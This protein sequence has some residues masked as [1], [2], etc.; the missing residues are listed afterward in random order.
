MLAE[1]G[2]MA[3][4]AAFVLVN[5]GLLMILF[6]FEE[7]TLAMRETGLLDG[8]DLIAAE[9]AL[10]QTLGEMLW[11]GA[12]TPAAPYAIR[13]MGVVV[14][15]ALVV[16]TLCFLA[17]ILIVF[18]WSLWEGAHAARRLVLDLVDGAIVPLFVLWLSNMLLFVFL[19]KFI[20]DGT[21]VHHRNCFDLWDFVLGMWDLI[22]GPVAGPLRVLVVYL[23]ATVNVLRVDSSLF[24]GKIGWLDP[25]YNTFASTVMLSER[26]NNPVMCAASRLILTAPAD[27]AYGRRV[28]PAHCLAFASPAPC[29][30]FACRLPSE[31]LARILDDVLVGG[32][33]PSSLKRAACANAWRSLHL[34]YVLTLHPSLEPYNVAA[35]R[36]RPISG[37]LWRR[38]YPRVKKRKA[39]DA[40]RRRRQV[41]EAVADHELRGAP[42]RAAFLDGV[43]ELEEVLAAESPRREDVLAAESP[44]RADAEE[45]HQGHVS[46]WRHAAVAALRE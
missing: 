39:R 3:A 23:I 46:T 44:R 43:D 25:G 5:Y 28:R 16:A 42:M 1:A 21:Y 12:I 27:G 40:A 41:L 33:V 30:A 36:A 13:F 45:H 19:N 37:S 11:R 6:R 7:A 22:V 17:A 15:H 38:A 34:I 35:W 20:S 14:A 29:R 2:T 9:A 32:R 8:R 26:H 18:S 24:A 10:P 4:I 31:A